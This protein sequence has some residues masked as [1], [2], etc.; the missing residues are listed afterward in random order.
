MQ[1]KALLVKRKWEVGNTELLEIFFLQIENVRNVYWDLVKSLW[2][3][4]HVRV[5]TALFILGMH[6][7]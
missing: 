2:A 1:N 5:K 4:E 7:L 3:C 6:N